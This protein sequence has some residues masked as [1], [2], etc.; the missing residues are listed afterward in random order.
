MWLLKE[1]VSCCPPQCEKAEKD[2][3]FSAFGAYLIGVAYL[4]K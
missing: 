3:S 1:L 4:P 2:A